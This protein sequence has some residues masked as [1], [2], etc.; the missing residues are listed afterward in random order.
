MIKT[1][2]WVSVLDAEV[3][4]V[5]E[6]STLQWK[7]EVPEC[8]MFLDYFFEKAP[9]D[10][11]ERSRYSEARDTFEYIREITAQKCS[12]ERVWG[13]L[14]TNEI[15]IKPPKGK[16]TLIPEQYAAEGLQH[17]GRIVENN[18]TIKY[19]FVVGLQAN[20]FLQK[21]GF[22]DCGQHKEAFLKG[23]EARRVGLNSRDPFY[24][25]VDAKPYRDICF[26]VFDM[27]QNSKVK[28]VPILPA[29][30]IPLRGSDLNNFEQSYNELIKYMNTNY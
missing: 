3:L 23:A 21:N 28:V 25:P 5:G 19:I 7:D 14:F 4:L 12:P 2:D 20:Y 16:H 29:K 1:A 17:I 6:H 22:Y 15:L 13:T 27:T 24:Q 18:P 9:Y 8:A 11:G 26:R 30:S 10:L